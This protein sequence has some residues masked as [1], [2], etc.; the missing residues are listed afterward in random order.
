VKYISNSRLK[1]YHRCPKKYEFKYIYDL[2][3]KQRVM[4]LEKGTWLHVLLEEH[5]SGGDWKATHRE[6][7]IEFNNLPED[8]RDDLGHDMPSECARIMSN[9][10][11]F[12]REED[13]QFTVVDTEMDEIVTLPN[14]LPFRI[15]VDLIVED[16]RTGLLWPWD[17]KSRGKLESSDNMLLDP[18]L[19]NYFTGLRVLGYEPL[20]GVI[21]N[22]IRT[23]VPT[24]PRLLKSGKL[25]KEKKIDT[26]VYTYYRAIKDNGLEVDDY[27]DILR[28]IAK[29]SVDAWFRRTRLP[30]D[31]PMLKAMAKDLVVTAR[32]IRRS[33]KNDE[34][35]R[36][37]MPNDCKWSCDMKP[38]CI[39]Q[40]HGADISSLI[41]AGYRKRHEQDEVEERKR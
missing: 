4:V 41:K 13:K 31:T 38:L 17:H 28:H 35:P 21:Y 6:R 37:F 32:D 22:E 11:R 27:R 20:G 36:H 8:I 34:W 29:K 16:H 3:R 14:G 10:L 26:D 5:Y 15:I 40:L 24:V 2:E 23:K 12:W 1:T 18:Q 7:T 33:E 19:T 39:A 25:S 30:K 9:Y